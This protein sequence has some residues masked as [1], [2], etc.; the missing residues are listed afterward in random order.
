MDR[1]KRADSVLI[2][3][4]GVSGS[5]KSTIGRLLAAALDWPFFEGDDFHPADN[6]QKM[7][8]GISLGDADRK[9]W[10]TPLKAQIRV[11][12][13]AGQSAVISCSA[14]KR[15]YR[16]ALSEDHD[17]VFFVFLKADRDTIRRRLQGRTGHFFPPELMESQFRELEEPGNALVLDAALPPDRLVKM[18]AEEY[19]L[20]RN[21][22]DQT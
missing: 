9:Q 14:L 21:L 22:M 6:I 3:V 1:L 8:S 19:N 10:L 7:R 13:K 2:I 15:S 11:L 18:I 5:G 17:Q 16:D 20:K 12:H 4:A